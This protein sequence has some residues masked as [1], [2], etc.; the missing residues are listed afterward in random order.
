MITESID[1][2]LNAR[3]TPGLSPSFFTKCFSVG[4]TITLWILN[5]FESADNSAFTSVATSLKRILRD[6]ISIIFLKPV[7]GVFIVQQFQ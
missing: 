2:I 7:D 1:G 4:D 6:L 3:E 5:R